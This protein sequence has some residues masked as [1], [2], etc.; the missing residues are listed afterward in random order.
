MNPAASH[1][2]AVLLC[3][4]MLGA[5]D[6]Q[7]AMPRLG[8]ETIVDLQPSRKITSLDIEMGGRSGRAT[9]IDLNPAIGT[10]YLLQ[11]QWPGSVQSYHL[12]SARHGA[13]Q[14]RLDR[15][16][17]LLS[18]GSGTT[19]C[20]LW[21]G[22]PGGLLEQA[23]R[24]A[25]PYAPLCDGRLYLRNAV[26]GTY[27]RLERVTNF[28][29]D[30]VWG[31][32]RIV[33]FVRDQFYQDAFLE[34]ARPAPS[35]SSPSGSPVSSAPQSARLIAAGGVAILPEDIEVDMGEATDSMLLGQWYPVHNSPGIYLSAVQPQVVDA[36]V[37]AR[38]RSRVVNLDAVEAVALDYLVA[39]DLNQF[40]LGFSLGTDHPRLG[41]SERVLDEM[42]VPNLA[43]PDGIDSATPLARTGM[44]SP[45]LSPLVAATFAGG[46]KREH[47]A[48]HYGDLAYR[49]RGS[50][51]GFIE[52]GV[53]FSTLQPGL[54]TLYVLAD[55]TVG[56]KTW[57]H[58]DDAWLPRIRYA[59]QNGVALIDQD[60]VS[61]SP[62][63]GPLI[64]QWGPG[65]WSGSKDEQF[66]TLRAGTCLSETSTRRFLIYGYFSAA[67]P[68][69]MAR[70]FQ[71]YGCRYAMHLDM[72]ALEHTYLALY[73]RTAGRLLVQHLVR[74]M[75]E[76]DKKGGDQIAPRFLGFPDD[77]DF[78]YLL[79]RRD[80]S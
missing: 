20:P 51:Y 73:T 68:R 5:T 45:A 78:F 7:H 52:E 6:E 31:G 69:A 72:N 56:M 41:W 48:F 64:T 42:R 50:H 25:L 71:A 36:A 46:F 43:G 75:D 21:A 13:Q 63:P 34:Q 29:R 10:W 61:G 59:R 11:L 27:T 14:L 8:P 4:L 2:C 19:G 49:N 17:L 22:S 62:Q 74:G 40:E 54:S 66:R 24:S 35:R 12:E 39:F 1:V 53:V 58:D 76:V 23:Q 18:D 77:R 28:L 47:G 3:F 57:S 16:G 60:P 9:L 15:Q 70:V 44:V 38:L 33:S 55:G 65:N 32:D 30:R 80:A 79:R 37:A 26:A 67:T